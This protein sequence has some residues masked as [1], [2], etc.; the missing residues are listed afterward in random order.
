MPE[1][2]RQTEESNQAGVLGQLYAPEQEPRGDITKL[3]AQLGST[4]A[5]EQTSAEQALLKRGPEAV[6]ALIAV[7][8]TEKSN[9]RQ[10]ERRYP[11]VLIALSVIG[12]GV[13]AF[14]NIYLNLYDSY[15]HYVAILLGPLLVVSFIKWSKIDVN[16][17][18]YASTLHKNAANLLAKFEDERA[19]GPL[20]EGLDFGDRNAI[21]TALKRL[22]PRLKATDASLLNAKQ[23]ARLYLELKWSR[24]YEWNPFVDTEFIATILKAL[25]QIGDE[26]ALP[27]VKRLAR[28]SHRQPIR[29]AAQECLPFLQQ[30]LENIGTLL[31]AADVPDTHI[32]TLLHPVQNTSEADPQ[33]LLRR[34]TSQQ[35]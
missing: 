29:Q 16:R 15:W 32:D 3:I 26:T 23:R 30:R 8:K 5:A 4:D 22:L 27:Y 10:R 19:V 24:E 2:L 18:R 31:R 25:E 14:I 6:Q 33:T 35:E 13:P 28:S 9:L 11:L 21:K 20:I 7:M 1:H 34:D 12:T 17:L